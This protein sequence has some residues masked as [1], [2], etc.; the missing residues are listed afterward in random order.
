MGLSESKSRDL[1]EEYIARLEAEA[2]RA[3]MPRGLMDER[4]NQLKY[5]LH[6]CLTKNDW[7][8]T[9]GEW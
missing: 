3:M 4:S 7:Y 5:E 1:K 8:F 2:V 9:L 6:Y